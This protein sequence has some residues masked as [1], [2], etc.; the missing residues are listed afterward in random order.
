MKVNVITEL[1]NGLDR[2]FLISDLGF[3]K[4]DDIRIKLLNH[5]FELMQAGAD[6]VHIERHKHH[7][8]RISGKIFSEFNTPQAGCRLAAATGL[9][10]Q[11]TIRQAGNLI[12]NV[13]NVVGFGILPDV[14]QP[15]IVGQCAV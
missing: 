10:C 14:G 11:F 3:L 1:A 5:G 4:T 2:E 9:P 7:G 13:G 12:A 6:T 15:Q 8:R